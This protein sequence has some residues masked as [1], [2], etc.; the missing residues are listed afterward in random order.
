[1]YSKNKI[2]LLKAKHIIEQ[3]GVVVFPTETVYG[4]W[5]NALDPQAVKKVFKIKNRPADNPLIV[6]LGKKSNIKKYAYIKNE[7]QKL[8]IKYL[9][10]GPLTIVLL[11]KENIPDIVTA[12][13]QFV[14]IRIP[15]NKIA[16][17]F[18]T[19]INLPIVA[20]SANR[21]TESSPTSAQMVTKSLG[22]QVPMI[23]DWWLCEF[24]I[25]STVV[26][27]PNNKEIII[28]RP[29]VIT[30]EDIQSLVGS[31][32]KV[33]FSQTP[34]QHSPGNKYKHYAPKAKV[35]IFKNID[36]L[37][38][39]S[40][41]HNKI[42]LI[43]TSEFITSHKKKLNDIRHIKIYERWSKKNLITCAKNLFQLYH[44]CDEDKIAVVAIEALPERGIWYAIMNR[45]K[46]SVEK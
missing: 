32:V 22:K 2:H 27:V 17:D 34:S 14:A 21:S 39:F 13:S 25:E 6:H 16:K 26:M 19:I 28:L 18:L 38:A 44:K 29:G 4:L 33:G 37:I 31:S 45:V 36:E 15:S 7:L 11:K 42:W 24:G 41:K 23:I 3:W 43:A 12:G 35:N 40:K 10:P 5:A 1:M 8:I 20:P 9:M 30:K 46:K